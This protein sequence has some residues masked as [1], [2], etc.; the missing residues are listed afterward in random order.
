[1][2]KI[3]IVLLCLSFTF[4]SMF[5]GCAR[6]PA[7]PPAAGGSTAAG[8]TTAGTAP[9]QKIGVKISCWG[10][11]TDPNSQI[12]K[13]AVTMFN[14][15][16]KLNATA[17]VEFTEQEQYKT[18]IAAAMAANQV[19]DVFN[20][21]AAG[22]LKPFVQAGK[23]Y[24]LT[25]KL[26]S[27]TEWKNR[28]V[29]GVYTS[30]QFDGKVYA[31]PTTQTVA[32][33][34]YNKDIFKKYN[35]TEPK[36]YDD[37]LNIVKVLKDNGVTPFALG[38]KAP[39]VGAMLSEIIINRVGGTTPF[40]NVYNGTGTWED[41][42]FIEGGKRMAELANLG[43]FPTGFNALDNDPAQADFRAGKSG[44]LF[45]GSW[46]I[47]Q[48][49][50][51]MKDKLDVCKFPAIAGGKG[52]ADSWVGQP[53]QS[54]A[55]SAKSAVADAA[56]E[57]IKT[58]SD[59]AIQTKLNEAG[60]LIATN[61]TPDQSKV[62]PIALKVANLLKDM[63]E[64]FVFYDVGLGATIGNEYNNTIQAITAGKK[65][66]DAFKTLQQFTEQNK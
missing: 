25:G 54:F 27:D 45:M 17:A 44:M 3:S 58:V 26:N 29:P 43:A 37:L 53:D 33:L 28:Y 4:S 49:Y 14:Q 22:F 51:D 11:E 63:K 42:A 13:D 9:A 46:A 21:W 7:N 66:E 48:L 34:F 52:N 39:W 57:F 61:V 38:N 59:P 56:A 2:K 18:K 32:C 20:T 15:N 24:D 36:T 64:L 62:N 31:L 55:I 12:I 19:P 47:Q 5:A 16:N 50:T 8:S 40:N 35:L 10:I 23:V 65:P 6:N 30:L 41:P 60:N 1:M